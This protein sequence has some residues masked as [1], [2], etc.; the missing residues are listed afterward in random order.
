MLTKSESPE[1]STAAK[2]KPLDDIRD[3]ELRRAVE[4]DEF[5]LHYQPQI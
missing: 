4:L 5:V 3:E 2:P 1:E